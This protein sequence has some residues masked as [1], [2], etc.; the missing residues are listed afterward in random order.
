GSKRDWSS[1]VCSSDLVPLFV[2]CHGEFGVAGP[3]ADGHGRGGRIDLDLLGQGVH[4]N[5][6]V[7]GVGDPVEGVSAAERT[8]AW[9]VPDE[10]GQFLVA[11]G[12]VDPWAGVGEV[13]GPV[14]DRC[15]GSG[16]R[17]SGRGTWGPVRFATAD[18]L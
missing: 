3:R 7:P 17:V 13:P 14:A 6:V 2:Q 4:A 1:D 16:H 18:T 5:Q 11:G 8:D 9:G 10:G 15:V 12:A